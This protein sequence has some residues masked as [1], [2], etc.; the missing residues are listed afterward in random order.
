MKKFLILL[1]AIFPLISF[2]QGSNKIE[3]SILRVQGEFIIKQKPEN[4]IVNINLTQ[5]EVEYKICLDNALDSLK[6]L[7]KVFVKNG[8]N[9]SLIRT[10]DISIRENFDWNNRERIKLGYRALISIEIETKYTPEFADKLIKA[11]KDNA[12]TSYT[13]RF[14]LSEY[15]KDNLR[16]LALK[17]SIKDATEKA[18]IM[19]ETANIELGNIYRIIY[20]TPQNYSRNFVDDD[21]VT[22]RRYEGFSDIGNAEKEID[23]NPKEIMIKKSVIIEW[24]IKQ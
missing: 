12:N 4:I 2:G 10:K 5:N 7:K 17:E 11:L 15:Q 13:I 3:N 6:K 19:A 22:E 16:I 18:K 9:D 21:I 24:E 8:I 23:F 14:N 1:I 20:E